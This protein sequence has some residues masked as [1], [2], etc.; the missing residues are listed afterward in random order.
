MGSKGLVGSL[1][2]PLGTQIGIGADIVGGG[3]T[4]RAAYDYRGNVVSG[5]L[6]LGAEYGDG[7]LVDFTDKAGKKQSAKASDF[8]TNILP[9]LQAVG[10]AEDEAAAKQQEQL[11]QQTAINQ[12]ET[13]LKT[14]SR[15][16]PKPKGG[17]ILTSPLGL[18]GNSNSNSKTLI[19][20]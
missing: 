13:A 16:K 12:Q 10:K 14:V 1:F 7:D 20:A 8:I 5:E 11:N 2:G 9:E 4:T 3:T 6:D 19:G 18:L 17:T 15:S